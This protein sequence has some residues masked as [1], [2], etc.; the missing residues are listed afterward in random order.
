MITF[1]DIA[2]HHNGRPLF[3]HVNAQIM[4]ADKVVIAGRSGIGKTSLLHCVLGFVMPTSGAISFEGTLIDERSVWEVRRKIA[5]VNQDAN[6]GTGRI[7]D[8]IRSCFQLHANHACSS[9]GEQKTRFLDFLELPSSILEKKSEELSGGERQRMALLIALL[10]GR[11]VF[12]LDE[13]TANL[14]KD[15]KKKV[16][17]F[18]LAQKDWTI[19]CV[20]HDEL[21][22]ADPA[23][24]VFDLG[25][26]KWIR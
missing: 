19:V 17:D 16:V 9:D 26:K 8:I 4:R 11:T 2:L 18:F 12:F 24:K 14:D 23:V 5:Y 22:Q 15:L 25:G 3:E 21:W 7:S 13:V 1:Q 10:L 20:S 6:I